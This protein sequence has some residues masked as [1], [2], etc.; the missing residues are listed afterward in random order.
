M[1]YQQQTGV[2]GESLLSA[3]AK[4]RSRRL[5]Y[6]CGFCASLTSI[7]LGYDVRGFVVYR[8]AND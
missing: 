3:A 4:A 8:K 7:L 1:D 6:M 2:E 5:V